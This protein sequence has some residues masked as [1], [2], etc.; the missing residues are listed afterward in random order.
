MDT[1]QINALGTQLSDLA[2][3][4]ADLRRYL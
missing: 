4:T 3:R 1:E 2:A